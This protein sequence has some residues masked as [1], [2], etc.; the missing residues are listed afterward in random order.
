MAD[1]HVTLGPCHFDINETA[2]A[3]AVHKDGTGWI[4][5][6][7]DHKKQ[8]EK[9][10]Y[11]IRPDVND[12]DHGKADDAPADQADAESDRSADEKTDDEVDSEAVAS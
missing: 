4:P 3:V 12:P 8:A 7:G 11:E 9:D 10:G 6:C 5:V 2:V 1:D